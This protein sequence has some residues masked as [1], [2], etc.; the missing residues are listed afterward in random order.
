[1]HPEIAHYVIQT[2]QEL[3]ELLGINLAHVRE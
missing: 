2:T 1:M 3:A